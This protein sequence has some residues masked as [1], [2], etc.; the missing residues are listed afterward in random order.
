MRIR[1]KLLLF[2]SGLLVLSAGLSVALHLEERRRLE[3]ELE[4]VVRQIVARFVGEARPG[5][6]FAPARRA[7]SLPEV[8]TVTPRFHFGKRRWSVRIDRQVDHFFRDEDPYSFPG[9][10]VIPHRLSAVLHE[11]LNN[12]IEVARR[13]SL[14]RELL[15]SGAVL[16]VGLG[17][18]GLLA[19]RLTRPV[20]ELTESMERVAR[21]DLDVHV[22]PTT[23]DE[24]RQMS[25]SFNTMVDRL[26][27]KQ[28]LE[29]K[30]FQAERLS[31]MGHLAAGV[32]H[33][34]RNPLNT[35][36]LTLN[37][38]RDEYAPE[39]SEPREAYLGHMSD[40]RSELDR[41]NDLVRN[42]LALARPDRGE[43]AFCDLAELVGD[44]LRLFRR[45]AESLGVSIET[46]FER[47]EPLFLN[48][49][50]MRGAVTN[51]VINALRA[52]EDGGGELTVS[53]FRR[54]RRDGPGDGASEVVLRIGD[55]GCGIEPEDLDRIFLPYFTTR[56]D[57]TGLGLPIARG[58][59][60]ANGGRIEI[61]SR[62]GKG[63]DVDLVVPLGCS[64]ALEPEPLTSGGEMQ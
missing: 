38:L 6:L 41:L 21:G 27:E 44:A 63:T 20:N 29:R 24:V 2:T 33:D 26:R 22:E 48:P 36:G 42:F 7:A 57:G 4:T 28:L 15:I 60:E 9:D 34:V 55:T 30:M 43:K 14:P 40:I 5:G 47:F 39:E 13:E 46:Q 12:P 53:L 32:A 10:D 50:Q 62:P 25:E 52:M 37:H 58:A 35:I 45:Q 3:R 64:R 1:T 54:P 59:L 56:E 18:T 51:V 23:R 17:L 16:L 49:H 61:R 11:S 8:E 31:A 19:G